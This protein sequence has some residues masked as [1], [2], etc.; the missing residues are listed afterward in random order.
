MD[1]LDLVR[2]RYLNFRTEFERVYVSRLDQLTYFLF[3][4]LAMDPYT[5]FTEIV[6]RGGG[7]VDAT[8]QSDIDG[9]P[10]MEL[11]NILKM[12]VLK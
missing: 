9:I 11:F 3:G 1:E 6:A 5:C 7:R 8:I 2:N 4:L 12:L 10:S